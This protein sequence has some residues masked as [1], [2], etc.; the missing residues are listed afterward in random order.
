MSDSGHGT[1]AAAADVAA[2]IQALH[3][4]FE[5]WF[6]GRSESLARVEDALAHDFM[7]VATT[8]S[9]IPRAT[10][11]DGIRAGRGSHSGPDSFSIDVADVKIGW[12]RGDL[13]SATYQEI[14]HFPA[15]TTSRRSTAVFAVD[16]TASGG[17][18]WLS[19]HETWIEPPPQH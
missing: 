9:V 14:Q 10:L 19:V 8:G 1:G 15:F 16:P 5:Q 2:E 7:F 3:T 4:E 13:I 12:R 6:Y 11:M 18:R 17:L